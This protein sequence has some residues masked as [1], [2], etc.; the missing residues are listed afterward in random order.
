M[1]CT[2]RGKEQFRQICIPHSNVVECM[3]GSKTIKMYNQ[4]F[5]D[6]AGVAG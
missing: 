5:L 2:A 4:Q 1:R 6:C 3:L